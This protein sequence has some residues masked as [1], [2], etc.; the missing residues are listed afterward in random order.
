MKELV[1]NVPW[2][3]NRKVSNCLTPFDG[4]IVHYKVWSSR[5]R[6]HLIASNI[7]WG[8][9]LE[10]IEKEKTPLTLERLRGLP[11]LDK[12]PLTHVGNPYRIL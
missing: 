11:G 9:L 5:V 2:I 8:R 6:D 1:K 12:A 4:N 10:A 7:H 3:I